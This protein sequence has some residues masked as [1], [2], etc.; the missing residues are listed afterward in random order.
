MRRCCQAIGGRRR[1]AFL[2]IGLLIFTVGV[3]S[4]TPHNADRGED[5]RLDRAFFVRFG[6]DFRDVIRS[7]AHWDGPDFITLAAVSG[8]GLL[9][10]S[11][12]QAIQDWAQEGRTP[13][14]NKAASVFSFLGNGATLLGLNA[15]IY[16]VGE[17]GNNVGLR[18]TAL[19][20]LESLATASA[21]VWTIKC[22]VG[23][24]RPATG[25]SSRHF[26]PFS[27]KNSYWSFPSGHA[28]AS[29]SVA[30]TIAEQT[31]SPLV[32][33]LAYGLATLVA[34]SRIHENTHWAS[35]VVIGSALGYFIGKKI[36]DLNKQKG[37]SELQI[38]F[39]CAAG[40][41]ALTLSIAF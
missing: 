41:R 25:E 18:R 19:L 24:A 10:F 12:D 32:D 6:R 35:D 40:R 3:G 4:A 14:S 11:F 15:I 27:F 17:L 20:S 1:V 28:I 31:E 36:C 37:Q 16:A 9:L 2:A 26:H 5:A 23:R 38:G 7:P 30:T 21:M 33:V 13:G 34:V 22:I 39:D 29:F 8:T